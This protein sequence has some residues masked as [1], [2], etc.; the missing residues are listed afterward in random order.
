[1][2]VE[3]WPRENS[4]ISLVAATKYSVNRLSWIFRSQLFRPQ[5]GSVNRLFRHSRLAQSELRFSRVAPDG[6]TS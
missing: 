1:M 3:G 5:C 4:E 2:A 6:P